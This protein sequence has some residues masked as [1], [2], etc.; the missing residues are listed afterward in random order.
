MYVHNLIIGLKNIKLSER[1][2][3]ALTTAEKAKTLLS[4]YHGT[5]HKDCKQLGEMILTLKSLQ[6]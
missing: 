3:K 2:E 1:M 5:N 4:L 6:L